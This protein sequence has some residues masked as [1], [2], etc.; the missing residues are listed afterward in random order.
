MPDPAQDY[1]VLWRIRSAA[2]EEDIRQYRS[3]P[4]LVLRAGLDGEDSA[5]RGLL[6]SHVLSNEINGY[7]AGDRKSILN[8]STHSICSSM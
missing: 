5:D 8:Q 3:I 4:S 6:S 7:K 2:S 1:T